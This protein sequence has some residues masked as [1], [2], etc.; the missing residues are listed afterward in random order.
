MRVMGQSWAKRPC[1]HDGDAVGSPIGLAPRRN[2]DRIEKIVAEF[3]GE[4]PKMP[5]ILVAYRL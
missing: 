1:R 4:P 3:I 5:N 2:H